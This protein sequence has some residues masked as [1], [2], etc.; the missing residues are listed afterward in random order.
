MRFRSW[1]CSVLAVGAAAVV[2]GCEE[3]AARTGAPATRSPAEP[4]AVA[5]PPSTPTPAATTASERA[6]RRAPPE[7]VACQHVL[8]AYRGAKRAPRGVTRSKSAARERATEVLEKARKGADFSQLARE[9]SDDP[10]G[11]LNRGN[12]GLFKRDAMVKKFS[13]AAFA[14]E[15][16]EVSAVVETAFG[17]HIIKRN[18]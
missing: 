18:Q 12:L 13:D 8:V 17:F 1:A 10:G 14:L 4:A 11:K 7:A 9:Y 2:S 6:E 3:K 16:G 5:H 15:V